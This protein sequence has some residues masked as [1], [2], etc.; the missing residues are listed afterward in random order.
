MQTDREALELQPTMEVKI[1]IGTNSID[2]K[3]NTYRGHKSLKPGL[4]LV[5]TLNW[6]KTAPRSNSLL[7]RML[8]QTRSTFES[9]SNIRDITVSQ[10]KDSNNN[11]GEHEGRLTGVKV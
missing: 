3:V 1:Q 11:V 9:P 7:F 4:K 5:E 8:S 10:L 2:K 6:S